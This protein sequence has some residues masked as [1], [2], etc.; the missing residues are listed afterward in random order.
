MALN[1]SRSAPPRFLENLEI[2]TPM[3]KTTDKFKIRNMPKGVKLNYLSI[4][5]N[6][7]KV[8]IIISS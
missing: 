5:V 1:F 6:Y 3:A 8:T 7:M 2:S 4:H